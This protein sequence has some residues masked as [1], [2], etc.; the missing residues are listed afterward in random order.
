MTQV[1]VR[2]DE[3]EVAAIDRLVAEGR[4][5]SRAAAIRAALA[6]QRRDEQDQAIAAAYARGYGLAAA[7]EPSAAGEAEA[8]AAAS[9]AEFYRDEPPWVEGPAQ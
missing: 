8:I 4:Y 3:E 5:A 7:A 6:R 9:I 1:A 2:L